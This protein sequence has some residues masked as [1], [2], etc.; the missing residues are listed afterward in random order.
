MSSRARLSLEFIARLK[1]GKTLVV[2]AGL[3]EAAAEEADGRGQQ[4][5]FHEAGAD[6]RECDVDIA[7]A[8]R[9]QSLGDGLIDQR[10]ILIDDIGCLAGDAVE[11]D[12]LGKLGSDIALPGS[13]D[14]VELELDHHLAIA[15]EQVGQG[16]VDGSQ[17]IFGS[18]KNE[19]AQG[20]F[21][22]PV[23]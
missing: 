20:L 3:G 23:A 2:I 13:V 5:A 9:D 12:L 18:A 16:E 22:W 11:A 10:L 21:Q 4:R 14:G 8:R 6:E 19:I 7:C 15:V 17:R 1:V